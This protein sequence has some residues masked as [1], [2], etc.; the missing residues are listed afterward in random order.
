MTSRSK[1]RAASIALPPLLGFLLRVETNHIFLLAARVGGN[2]RPHTSD[3][4]NFL[5]E[6]N[7]SRDMKGSLP[8]IG[9]LRPNLL[10]GRGLLSLETPCL[11][12]ML[13]KWAGEIALTLRLQT[14]SD[15]VQLFEDKDNA[16]SNVF[17]EV[18]EGF[19]DE[20]F[21]KTAKFVYRNLRLRRGVSQ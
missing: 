14:S 7:M 20:S 1:P 13:K 12:K 6:E 17:T 8:S 18:F 11:R 15:S 10:A 3:L 4:L 9:I 16:T 5:F 2:Q 21:T 19:I